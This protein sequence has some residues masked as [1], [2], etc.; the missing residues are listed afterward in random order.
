MKKTMAK[1]NKNKR[2]KA[3]AKPPKP[4]EKKGWVGPVV[5]SVVGVLGTLGGMLLQDYFDV[6]NTHRQL[7]ISYSEAAE[8]AEDLVETEIKTLMRELGDPNARVTDAHRESLRSALQDLRRDAERLTIQ[9]GTDEGRYQNYARAMA[10]LASALDETS[11][12][13]DADSFIEALNDFYVLQREF[14]AG[15]AERYRPLS[16]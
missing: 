13:A 12:P 15:I 1:A 5:V 2:Q 11:G 9:I 16:G 4:S 6:L 7:A 8:E 3:A 10:D 14:K